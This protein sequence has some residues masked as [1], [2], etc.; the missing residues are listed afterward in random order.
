MSDRHSTTMVRVPGSSGDSGF[1]RESQ[2]EE[3]KVKTEPGMEALEAK[4]SPPTRD[5][6]GSPDYQSF[7]RGFDDKKTKE[8]DRSF[9]LE[10][11]PQPPPRVPSG[12]TTDRTAKHDPLGE[13]PSAKTEQKLDKTTQAMSKKKTLKTDRVQKEESRSERHDRSE[14]QIV[15]P[16]K[17]VDDALDMKKESWQLDLLARELHWKSLTNLLSGDPV[18]KILKPK[19]IGEIQGPISPPKMA[20]NAVEGISATIQLLQEA[21]YVAGAFD[22]NELLECDQDQV[23]H[24]CRSLYDKLIPLTG[25]HKVTDQ[26]AASTADAPRE[27]HTGSSQYASAESEVESDDSVCIQRMSLGPSGA[28]HLR[29]RVETIK[30]DP[31]STATCAKDQMT[32][33]MQ[34]YLQK[35]LNEAKRSPRSKATCAKDQMTPTMQE[36][37]QKYLDEA[38]EQVRQDQRERVYQAVYPSRRIKP[39]R[40]HEEYTPDVEMESVQSHISRSDVF[41]PEDSDPEDSGQEERRHAM[42]ATTGT[43]QRGSDVPQRIRVS[44][45]AELKEFSGKDR[46]EDRARS[47]IGKVKSA[48]LRDQASDEE[49]CLVFGDLLTGPA[50]NWYNQLSRST[51]KKWKRLLDDFM[52]QYGGQGVSMARQYYLARKRSD[53]NPQE[54]LHR[55]NVA[56]KHAKI[57]IRDERMATSNTR[58]EHVEHFIATLDDRDLA[59]QLTLLRLADVNDLED[60][61]RA[62]QRM[63]SRQLKTSMGSNRFH[64]RANASSN[65]TSSKT[66]RAVRAIRERIESSGSESD[67]I[68]FDEDKDRRRICV[69]TAAGQEKSERDHRTWQKKTV[70]GD[71]HDR[72]GKPKACTHC[73]STRHD[74]R[75]CWQRLTCQ[76][77][78]RKGHPSDKCFYIC[79]A[80]GEIHD[81]GKCPMEEFF[82]LIRQWYVPTKHAGMF[83]PKVEEMLN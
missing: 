49:R 83:P 58:R 21:G 30:R 9:D 48:F 71:G 11:K 65:S 80:C 59:K 60:T 82:N 27:Y 6:K 41:D 7:G 47:W 10:D 55:L 50:R 3:V 16:I 76:K 68:E 26:T 63:E 31:R 33:T 39:A 75:G 46:D 12:T 78:G 45:I 62:Y 13:N 81:N 67:S 53:E 40:S 56:A 52:I 66:A 17:L 42:V 34:G 64:P 51:R 5:F 61:L 20:T 37:L 15:K 79:A 36:H 14:K 70:E 28:A 24:A 72:S 1:H 43:L 23:I 54:Y 38:K 77:C 25:K 2:D 18:L 74:D 69:T 57:A 35:Y 19:L 29:D 44:A 22:T 73:G 32:A 4:G 8:E